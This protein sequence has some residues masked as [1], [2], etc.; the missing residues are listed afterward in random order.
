MLQQQTKKIHLQLTG[1]GA[2][3]W[4]TGS[5]PFKILLKRIEKCGPS[6]ALGSAVR[7]GFSSGD[8]EK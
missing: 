7:L 5:I 8:R 6:V 1:S 2:V 4:S 3:I